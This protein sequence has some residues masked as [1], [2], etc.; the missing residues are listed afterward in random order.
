MIT[1]KIAKHANTAYPVIFYLFL[2]FSS[3]FCIATRVNNLFHLTLILFVLSLCNRHHLNTLLENSRGKGLTFIAIIIFAVYF[4]LSNLWGGTA[5]NLTSTLTHGTYLFLYVLI[6]GSLLENT[7]SRQ[8]ALLSI[9]AGISVLCLYSMATDSSQILQL[10]TLSASNPGPTNVIDLAGYCGVGIFIA[11]MLMKEQKQPLYW[12]PILILLS[13]MMLTQSR[14]PLI[15]CAIAFLFTLHAKLL[16]PRN[17][18]AAAILA[19]IFAALLVFTPAG[20]LLLGR[21]EALGTQSG[22]RLSIWQH[23]LQEVASSIWLGRGFVFDLDFIN[24]SGEHITTTHSVYLGA[25]LKGGI[26]GLITLGFVILC[27]LVFASK[28]YFKDKRYETALFIYA[29]IFMSSQGM[30]IISNPRES[31]ILFWLP[32]TIVISNSLPKNLFYTR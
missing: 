28:K 6:L 4:A 1:S 27:G 3:I 31:W 17:M 25:L 7:K 9:V 30:F 14:G 22:L 12:I 8:I 26:V 23:T 18:T 16:T 20:D 29:L 2:F 5:T 32:L 21:F 11:A 10:R 19:L 24:Y 13:M 15:S